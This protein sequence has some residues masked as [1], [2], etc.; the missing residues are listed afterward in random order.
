MIDRE[1]LGGVTPE[2]GAWTWS[3]SALRAVL[4]EGVITGA[5][6]AQRCDGAGWC[7]AKEGRIER[8][9]VP[10]EEYEMLE[11]A[12][13]ELYART[14]E[15][16]ASVWPEDVARV[17]DLAVEAA[18]VI[19][20]RGYARALDDASGEASRVSHLAGDPEWVREHVAGL[21]PQVLGALAD[22]QQAP[23]EAEVRPARL[24]SRVYVSPAATDSREARSDWIRD[25]AATPY[26]WVVRRSGSTLF[27]GRRDRGARRADLV[28]Q[29]PLSA[30]DVLARLLTHVSA[31]RAA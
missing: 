1:R 20:L 7:A 14:E 3:A 30:A 5:R 27:I 18:V 19:G 22:C 4:A 9:Q 21:L 15:R 11:A 28:L 6:L 16:F 10:A 26:Q 31:A 29:V 23:S 17:M 2:V 12:V 13:E 25:P 24:P 8:G